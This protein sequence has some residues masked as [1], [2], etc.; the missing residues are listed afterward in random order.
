MGEKSKE[1][2]QAAEQKIGVYV[3][4]CGG[5]ISDHVDVE[6]VCEN[7]KKVPG[8]TSVKHNMFMCSDPGQELIM[9]DLKEGAIDRV[10]VASCA[11]A[12]HE[13]TFRNAISRAG[14]NPFMY[15]HANI[16]EQV[17]WVHHGDQA[18]SKASRLVAAAAAKT[19]RLKPLEPFRVDA[20][21]H[22]T[23]IGGGVAGLKA[24]IDLAERGI[25]V[26]LIE[27]SPF[28][29]GW[30]A[31]WDKIY[32]TNEQASE[33]LSELTR[34]VL[35]HSSITVRNCSTV[36]GFGGY[37]GNFQLSVKREAPGA[38]AYEDE[39]KR[40]SESGK[41]LGE[42]IPFAGVCPE[43]IPETK[44]ELTIETG[45]VVLATGFKPYTPYRGEYG[46]GDFEEVITLP[47][48]IRIIAENR[49]KGGGDTLV[50]N[51]R[52]IRNMAMV[53]CVGSR[54]IPGLHQADEKG[55][56]NEYC[57]R[58]CCSTTLN[59][60]NIVREAHPDTRVFDFYRDIRT[61]GRGQEDIYDKASSNKVLFFRFDA[62]DPPVITRNNWTNTDHPLLM[63]V[64]D[65]L[66]FGEEL[67]VPVD[68][69]V[70]SVGME[71]RDVSDLTDMMKISTGPDRFLLE[72]HPKL[73]PVEMSVAGILIAGTCQAPFDMGEACAAASGA[74][75]KAA[76]ILA[77]GYVELDPYVAEVDLEKCKGSGACM[78]ACLSEGVLQM[79]DMTVDGE[80]VKRAQV[81]PA[82]C[83]G[84]GACTAVCPEGAISVV[85]W[86]LQQY[87]DMVDM[88]V[89]DQIAV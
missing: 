56:L 10:V 57:S 53:H 12:L 21:K 39:I 8:V 30:T 71:S 40:M 63:T 26:T 76:A 6:R 61:Y 17:S 67:E 9:E 37:I 4:H 22:A 72:V 68:L 14:F 20:K 11:P 24:A 50:V 13:T 23:V 5:N 18:T 73:R 88:I 27:K 36:T 35:N 32:P 25:E 33:L 66:T 45:V 75:V 65:T 69:I 86:T 47:D 38:G 80:N 58:T 29:G 82:R 41:E 84:C 2:I 59:T 43:S 3:C 31:K 7:A 78:D 42:F 28:L 87:E 46:Y 60:A 62:P 54:Q 19:K 81:N 83:E 34:E 79:V 48:L 77:R 1:T 64:K 49:E 89:S 44:E 51:G 15:D 70:L 74:G 52:K 16:R 55:N 85:G